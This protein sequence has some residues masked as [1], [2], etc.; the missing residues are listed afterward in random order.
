MQKQRMVSGRNT[1]EQTVLKRDRSKIKRRRFIFKTLLI[2]I[3]LL[4]GII[5]LLM[6]SFFNIKEIHVV[7]NSRC[8]EEEI[9]DAS[10]VVTGVNGFKN[11]GTGIKHFIG[12]RYGNAE[13]NILQFSSYVKD[14][15]VKFVLPST[16]KIIIKERTPICKSEFMGSYI[17]IDEECYAVDRITVAK[18]NNFQDASNSQEVNNLQGANNLQEVNYL[19]D[20]NNLPLVKGLVFARYELGQP[21]AI[22]EN[23]NFSIVL[24]F[25]RAVKNFDNRID[26]SNNNDNNYYS[27]NNLKIYDLINVI[28]V[29]NKKNVKVLI[30]SRLTVNFGSL[31]EIDYRLEFLKILL[32]GDL[33]YGKGILN[34]T[35]G[36]KPVFTPQY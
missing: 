2:S 32:N 6:S 14:V 20:A 22:Q 12:L 26:K 19:Q 21:L 29:A 30:D 5:L 1:N 9:I 34:F 31:E 15:T 8:K 27:G 36:D 13:K 4:A 18:A 28:D 17:L 25:L 33:K 7:G 10:G 35:M 3:L 16:V 11:V 23:N 24:D